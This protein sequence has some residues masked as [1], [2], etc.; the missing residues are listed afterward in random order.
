MNR[1]LLL[2]VAFLILGAGVTAWF[3][4]SQD[5]K[6]SLLAAERSFAVKDTASIHRIF[7]ADRLGR[8]TNLERKDGYWL[9]NGQFKARATAVSNVLDAISRIEVRFKPARAAVPEMVKNLATEGLK[10]E[11]YDKRGKLIKSYYIGGATADERGTFMMNADANEPYVT[12]IAGW[13]GNLRFRYNLTG[14]DWRDR[15]V[16]AYRPE[17]IMS[18]S[19]DYPKQKNKSF[20]LERNGND[21]SVSPFYEISTKIAKPV[22]K[23]TAEAYLEGFKSMVAEGFENNLPAKD[24]ISRLLPFSVVTVKDTKGN[25]ATVKFYP[26][27]YEPVIDSKTGKALPAP[28]IER[29]Y[30]DINGQDFML[31]QQRVFGKIF[32]AYEAF[33]E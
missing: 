6:T 22:N 19:V 8:Q 21:F 4:Y 2:F 26:V 7:I 10:V 25:A 24:S 17:D 16:F 9:Y 33:F 15:T 27:F 32:W 3:L 12:Q 23:G 31:V 14:D 1:T 11:L 5:D 13:D 30:A 28:E 29:Y 18:V 20:R